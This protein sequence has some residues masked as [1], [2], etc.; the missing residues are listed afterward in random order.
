MVNSGK[1]NHQ[2]NMI[3]SSMIQ[4][5][6]YGRFDG[7]KSS[8]IVG[9]MTFHSVGNVI[10]LAD[11]HFFTGVGGEKPPTSKSS[12]FRGNCHNCP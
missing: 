10:I 9:F 11:F 6:L 2:K 7:E 12:F 4:H 3:K 8:M 5:F 1:Q